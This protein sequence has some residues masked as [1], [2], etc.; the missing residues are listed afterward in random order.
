V[1]V[2]GRAEELHHP[3]DLRHVAELPLRFWALGEKGHWIRVVPEQVTGRRIWRR[4]A[5]NDGG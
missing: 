5:T 4:G 1:M 2:K 3:D